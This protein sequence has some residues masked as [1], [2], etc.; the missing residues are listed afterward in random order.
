MFNRCSTILTKNFK[1]FIQEMTEMLPCFRA[2]SYRSTVTP[3]GTAAVAFQRPA[4][5]GGAGIP[6]RSCAPDQMF[7]QQRFNIR[8]SE[9][10]HFKISPSW[11]DT[12]KR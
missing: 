8:P 6:L 2:E 4:A 9:M 7:R 12:K 10:I 5:S 11:L 3:P 1:T